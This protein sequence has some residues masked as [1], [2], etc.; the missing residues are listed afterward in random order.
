M[1]RL[2]ACSLS[3]RKPSK[4]ESAGRFRRYIGKRKKNADKKKPLWL[5]FKN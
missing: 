1:A 5:V 3:Y 2:N 4:S